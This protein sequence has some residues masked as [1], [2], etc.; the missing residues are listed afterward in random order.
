VIA[1]VD[2]LGGDSSVATATLTKAKAALAAGNFDEA[3][4][5]ANQAKSEAEAAL[6]ARRA[7]LASAAENNAPVAASST[8]LVVDGDS[9]WSIAGNASTYGDPYQW[10]LIYKANKAKIKDAD[11]IEPGQ[12][13]DITT[14]SSS[15]IKAAVEYAKTRGAWSFGSIEASDLKFLT[16]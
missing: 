4:S 8:Y 5:L 15:E 6:A 3:I 7:A 14:G 13:F 11:A 12:V 10:P 1:S 2:E 9:L 16:P